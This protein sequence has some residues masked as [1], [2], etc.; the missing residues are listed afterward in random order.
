M[1]GRGSPD[2][3]EARGV[4]GRHWA[5]GK[6]VRPRAGVAE[7]E[8]RSRLETSSEHEACDDEPVLG[9]EQ[10]ERAACRGGVHDFHPDSTFER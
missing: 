8:R 7:L 10:V 4:P 6:Q 1:D 5:G 2:R 3:G 9:G